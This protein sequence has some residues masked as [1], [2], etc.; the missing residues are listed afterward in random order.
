MLDLGT[1]GGRYS[2]SRG[3]N[4]NGQVTGQSSLAGEAAN[5][6]FLYTN[7]AGRGEDMVDLGTLGGSYSGGFAINDAGQVVG[8]SLT[9]DGAQHIFLYVGMPGADGHMID[10]DAWLDAT[11]PTEGAKWT[12][13]EAHGINNAGLITGAGLFNDG[14]GGLSDGKRAFVL[15][16]SSLVPE[17]HSC[18]LL[19][20]C[21]AMM[22][23]RRSQYPMST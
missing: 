21:A 20:V 19:A 13:T 3:I 6:A 5:H 9:A 2:S 23:R 10:L 17:P 22:R 4:D 14:P 1:L 12:L 7:V 18:S 11:N 15:D 16:V 8:I